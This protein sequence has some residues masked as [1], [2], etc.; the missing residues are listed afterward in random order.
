VQDPWL[1]HYQP[2]QPQQNLFHHAKQS[3]ID[4]KCPLADNLQLA[5]WPTQY[6]AAPPPK[7]Y[8]ESYQRK[9]LMSYEAAIAS[10]GRDDTTFTKLFIISLKNAAANLHVR[11]P[12]RSV[13]SWAHLKEKFLVNFQG[14]HADITTEEDFFSY[15]QYERETLPDFFHRLFRLKAQAPEVS[16]EQAITHVIKALRAGQLHSHLVR[17]RS[18]TLEGLYEEFRKFSR[19]EVSHYCKLD[20]QRK[21]TNEN[22]C[23]RPFKYSK[24]KEGATSFHIGRK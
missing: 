12:P 14:F 15:Q 5:P 6:R 23:S 22:E 20:Q 10:F 1:Q 18:K 16:D 8:G 13:T 4:P 9:F 3:S 24:G 21:V 17:E 19:S 11:L 2:P 7:Y